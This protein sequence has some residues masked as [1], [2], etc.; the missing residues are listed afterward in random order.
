MELI[1]NN[2]YRIVGLLVG[3]TAREKE[4]QIKRLK[5]FIEAEQ[6]PQDDFS[7]P[8]LG[9]LQRTIENVSYATSKLNLDN[10]KMNS[11]LFWF[12]K[13]NEITDEPALD[14]LKDGDLQSATEIWTKL[15]ASGE[16]TQRNCSAFQNLSNL[17]LCS[18]FNNSTINANQLS[19]GIA[20][21]L[22][23]LESDLVKDFKALATDETYKTSK[24]ELQL[25]FLNHLQSEIDGNKGITSIQFL[26]II[27]KQEFSAK[28][29]FLKNYV[30]KPIEQIEKK[31]EQAKS[32]RKTNKADAA[33]AGKALYEQTSESISQLKKILG[34]SNIKFSAISDKI[35]SEI[36]QCGID[37]FMFNRDSS[38]N[39]TSIP[40]HHLKYFGVSA[41]EK[42]TD[43]SMD[44]F[45]KAKSLAIGNIALERCKENT[46]GLQEWIEGKPVREKQNL[47]SEDLQFITTRLNIF[48]SLSTTVANVK[49]LIDSCKP[50][51]DNIKNTLGKDD[52]LYLEIS[53]AVVN[54]AQGMLVTIVNDEQVLFQFMGYPLSVDKAKILQIAT[55]RSRESVQNSIADAINNRMTGEDARRD[56]LINTIRGA[57]SVSK[58]LGELDMVSELRTR[59]KSNYSILQSLEN[60]LGITTASYLPPLIMS[61]PATKYK[62]TASSSNTQSDFHFAENAWWILGIVGLVIGAM[63]GGAIAGAIIGAGI[64]AVIYFIEHSS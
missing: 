51:L 57:L 31:I 4:R 48:Q 36:L 11:A 60:K 42:F 2:P 47:I 44:L 63:A 45:R 6:E 62:P 10:D 50:K 59:Y 8:I 12:Y 52:E 39:T 15:I 7:F 21:K 58:S 18:A 56:N 16:V 34:I 27:N 54:N 64:G 53:S 19:Q 20:L 26:D 14:S 28:E 61:S 29:E 35:S 40:G 30:Q 24:K 46:D 3:A 9:Q 13:F 17:I 33:K 38:E 25:S 22:K 37:Y 23:F 43:T 49:E 55:R 1:K 41:T 5:Q 32:R